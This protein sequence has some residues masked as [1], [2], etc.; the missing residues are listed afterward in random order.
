ME[1]GGE[2][3]RL[4]SSPVFFYEILRQNSVEKFRVEFVNPLR[5]FQRCGSMRQFTFDFFFLKNESI[6]EIDS[7]LRG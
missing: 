7:F 6:R 5:Y 2:T 1:E 3:P 4:Y